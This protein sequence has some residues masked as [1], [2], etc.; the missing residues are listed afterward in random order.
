VP[1][2]DDGGYILAN[3]MLEISICLAVPYLFLVL[4]RAIRFAICKFH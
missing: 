2:G 3:G 4:Y 1:F